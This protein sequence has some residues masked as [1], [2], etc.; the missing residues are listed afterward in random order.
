MKIGRRKYK[1]GKQHPI[2]TIPLLPDFGGVT[3][4]DLDHEEGKL[5][6]DDVGLCAIANACIHLEQVNLSGR[7][8]FK[9]IGIVSLVR[10]CKYLS[11]LSLDNCVNVT[12]K[13]L[14][15]IGEATCLGV[16][17]LRGCYLI[18]DLGLEYF[19]DGDLKY[20]LAR[21]FLNNCDGITNN[22]IVNLQKLCLEMRMLRLKGCERITNVGLR[23]FSGHQK[24]S[25]LS[26]VSC[27]KLSLEDV[28]PIVMSCPNLSC[29]Y[30]FIWDFCLYVISKLVSTLVS[31]WKTRSDV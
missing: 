9:E 10:S 23:A 15:M 11:M 16:L 14:K 28:K 26:L 18:S 20:S 6:F 30:Q 31:N 8:C 1:Q 19:V 25:I 27:Y 2:V 12:D 21:L 5:E 7:L 29:H 13:S 22:G 24:L 17:S 3:L 4:E